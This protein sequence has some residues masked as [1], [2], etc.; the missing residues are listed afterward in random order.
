MRRFDGNIAYDIYKKAT[1]NYKFILNGSFHT[2]SSSQFNGDLCTLHYHIMI[3]K[4]LN[5]I[6]ETAVL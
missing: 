2:L 5:T 1:R 4:L 3:K 6:K